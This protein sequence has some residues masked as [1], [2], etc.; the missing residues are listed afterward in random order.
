MPVLT[1]LVPTRGRPQNA[2]ELR[3]SFDDTCALDTGLFFVVDYDDPCRD[4]YTARLGVQQIIYVATDRRGMTQCLNAAFLNRNSNAIYDENIGFMGDDHRPRTPGW[5]MSYVQALREMGT[6]FVYGNDLLQGENIPTQV[7]M[8][9]DIP[10]ALKRM[11]PDELHHLF[12]DNYWKAVG[13]G[14]GRIRYLPDVVVE[15][16]HPLANKAAE[17]EG[18]KVVNSSVMA[19]HDRNAWVKYQQ[20]AL[21]RDIAV[22]RKYCNV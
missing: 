17:D 9:T 1:F 15:H 22:L 21:Q 7:A 8:T 13:E 3:R 4:E 14:L 19:I 11:V 16:M 6:G 20:G 2:V 10:F 12:V 18:Y 5:D